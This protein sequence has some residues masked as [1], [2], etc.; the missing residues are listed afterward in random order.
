MHQW[1]RLTVVSALVGVTTLVVA[2][3]GEVRNGTPDDPGSTEDPADE[4]TETGG[5]S[6]KGGGDDRSH[7]PQVDL[8][9]CKKGVPF[10]GSIT[11]ACNYVYEKL[12]YEDKL[13]ACACACK[14]QSGT[15]CASDFPTSGVPTEVMCY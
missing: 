9:D 6:G 14:K 5:T 11:L 2:C 13:A 8:P 1:H 10:P 4:I 7:L 3:G 15:I 12:C